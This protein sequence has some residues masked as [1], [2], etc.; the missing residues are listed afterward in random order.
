MRVNLGVSRK[1]NLDWGRAEESVDNKMKI[2]FE[3][4]S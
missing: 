2:T 4:A 3:G 1:E